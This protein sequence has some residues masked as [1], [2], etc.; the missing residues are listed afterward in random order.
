MAM[1]HINRDLDTSGA[2]AG[3]KAS[4]E[5]E[6]HQH[7]PAHTTTTR[8]HSDSSSAIEMK[9]NSSNIDKVSLLQGSGTSS[10][11]DSQDEKLPNQVLEICKELTVI[12]NLIIMWIVDL[13]PYCIAFLIAGSLAEAGTLLIL[14]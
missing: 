13:A 11:R 6:I 10:Q 5:M 12:S 14:A 4:A 3:P 2:G 9:E 7:H 8:L 1:V